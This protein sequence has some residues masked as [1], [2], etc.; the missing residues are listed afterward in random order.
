[1]IR[2][3]FPLGWSTVYICILCQTFKMVMV[4]PP[5]S[6]HS[7][8]RKRDGITHVENIAIH[9]LLGI[10]S[11][12]WLSKWLQRGMSWLIA[13]PAWYKNTGPG[14]PVDRTL[15]GTFCAHDWRRHACLRS[16]LCRCLELEMH[17]VGEMN[18]CR[19]REYK[20]KETENS[21]RRRT[22]CP[23]RLKRNS[24]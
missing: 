3:L 18:C 15:A 9:I 6:R 7:P 17:L 21:S 22:C 13:R 24:G 14:E 1:M 4:T 19:S 10:K 2:Q 12:K 5:S 11:I 16:N 20:T 8:V 23:K